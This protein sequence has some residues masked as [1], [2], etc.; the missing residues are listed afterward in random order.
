MSQDNN[1]RI[2][3]NTLLLYGRMLLMMVISLYTSRVILNALG[4]EDYGIYNVVGGVVAMFSIL[5]SS[6]AA[7]IS[8]FIT[9]EL[10]R[11][12]LE[13]LQKV[14]C[15][16]INVQLVLI[17]L[18]IPVI[19]I[20]GLWFLNY[21]MVIP[22]ER[23]AAANWVFQF[24]VIT[25]AINLM[26]VPYNAS[27]VAHER[28][29]VFAYISLFDA[30][31][32]LFVA[33]SLL[34]NPFD[35]LIY[36]GLFILLIGLIQRIIY[37]WYCKKNFKE[38][39]YKMAFDYQTTKDMFGFAGW[40]FIG[41]SSAVLR[42]QGGNMIIN[43]F[44]GPAVNAARGVAMS[45]NTAVTGF[46]G[47][48][49][50]AINPQITKCYAS[51][52][53]DYMFRLI[54]QGARFSFYIL[55]ILTLPIILTTQYLLELWLGGVPEHAANFVQLLLLYAMSESLAHPLVTAMLAT[56]KIRNYQ[57]IVGGCQ[58][59]NLPVSYFLFRLG[60][61]PES[62]FVVAI[63]VSIICEAARL[64]MLRT[65]IRLSVRSFLRNVYFNVIL[66]SIVSF[67]VPSIVENVIGQDSI[68]D[69]IIIC[70]VS[71]LSASMSIY[72][73]GCNKKDRTFIQNALKKI[74]SKIK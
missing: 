25:F 64:L 41:S 28:M 9:F 5:S 36:Y 16:A 46:V 33:F 53:Y 24:S 52:D 20:V 61:P 42:D 59:L 71:V 1:Q 32:K 56:G 67:I 6:L 50:T 58:L 30:V 49:M 10:G 13:K 26:S 21:K 7:A 47:S 14:F 54:F 55:L 57:L 29:S 43:L 72:F 39:R 8:R 60:Y 37:A 62:L 63:I 69:F 45:V 66:V 22:I 65:M 4:V 3:K 12:D 51:G 17:L 35:R 70:T 2:A 19:E 74:I 34:R 38:C 27:I 44:C 68:Y 11:G 48:F 15:A 40:N 23:L 31:A 73:I 18:I